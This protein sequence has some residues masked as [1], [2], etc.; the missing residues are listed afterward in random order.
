LRA[1]VRDYPKLASSDAQRI[2]HLEL[3]VVIVFIAAMLATN[4]ATAE[5]Y[6]RAWTDEAHWVDPAINL[7]RGNGL[8]SSTWYYS[9]FGQ[10]WF[11]NAPLYPVLLSAWAKITGDGFTALRSFSFVW[12]SLAALLLYQFAC[13]SSELISA[14]SRI[15][16]TLAPLL[17]YGVTFAYR[18]AR[19]DALCVFLVAL[20]L[21][22]TTLKNPLLRRSSVIGVSALFPWAGL[23]LPAY[24]VIASGLIVLGTG[25]R[26]LRT[27]F[28]VATGLAA[29]G[30]L[31][32]AFYAAAGHLH[33]FL[34]TT[35]LS[36]RSVLGQAAQY[37]VLSDDRG[38]ARFTPS[39][40]L[41]ALTEDPSTVLGFLAAISMMMTRVRRSPAVAN[42]LHAS[43]AAAVLIPLGMHCAGQ[44][45][46]Y[47]T[48]M[49]L[50]PTWF[51]ILAA[52]DRLDPQALLARL[53]AYGF[54][55]ASLLVG[56]PFLVGSAVVDAMGR[57]Y[58]QV[59]EF[60]GRVVRP[61]E[62]ALISPE[63]YFAVVESEGVP[64]LGKYYAV[65]R[66]MPDIPQDQQQRFSAIVA[67][68]RDAS[69]FIARLPGQWTEVARLHE[70]SY[71]ILGLSW[72]YYDGESD[73][74]DLIAYRR[75]H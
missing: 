56:W 22:V 6:P 12:I 14:Q 39:A 69:K 10:F 28:W 49:A 40:I 73:S 9:L 68:P 54:L 23:E 29:G 35:I 55:T 70:A 27:I 64:F 47:Y 16:L 58:G 52:V 19:P 32:L 30:C 38:A 50:V 18:S 37:I 45:N 2:T 33:D 66:L 31:M 11:G 74:Y 71:K 60:V 34:I 1:T 63:A 3:L 20:L 62:W 17:G 75:A 61:G 65:S 59:R 26:H 41:R 8:T 4:L 48:W 53:I 5:L 67:A 43:I 13:R 42:R 72:L 57:D 21:V 24:A 25:R 46:P 44:F 15:A 51:F 7:L 36:Q